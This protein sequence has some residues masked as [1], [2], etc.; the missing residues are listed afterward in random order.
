MMFD[1]NKLLLTLVDAGGGMRVRYAVLKGN[2]VRDEGE[3]AMGELPDGGS[4]RAS[5]LARGSYFDRADTEVRSAKMLPFQ[6]R[7][8]VDGA[9]AFNEPFRVRCIARDLGSGRKRL[10]LLA[11]AEAEYAAANDG[12]GARAAACERLAPVEAA[13]AALVAQETPEPAAVLWQRGVNLLGLLVDNGAVLAKVLDRSN[14]GETADAVEG[15]AGRLERM[16]GSLR[17]AARRIFPDREISLHLVLGDLAG[18][19]EA[20]GEMDNA[21]SSALETR[22][23]R[24][25][26]GGQPNAALQWPEVYGLLTLANEFS[27]LEPERQQRAWA[28]KA[29]LALGAVILTGAAAATATAAFSHAEWQR[30]A[31]EYDSRRGTVEA[32]HAA[33]KPRMPDPAQLAAMAQRVGIEGGAADF[34][35]DSLLAW[36]SEITPRGAII[37]KLEAGAAD[38]GGAPTAATAQPGAAPAAPAVAPNVSVE[39]ELQGDYPEIERL[40]AQLAER[41]GARTKLSG[42]MLTYTPGESGG[43]AARLVTT[44][45]P[46][47]GAFRQ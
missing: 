36:I 21:A 8:L 12:L 34:R 33:L 14:G 22:L 46:L 31:T 30:L 28:E 38:P 13:I 45:A 42:S 32:E 6:A 25:F 16:R 5:F 39:W 9:L 10:D 37:R 3:C 29:A 44:L 7:R 15:Q 19:P 40:A 20:R 18:K 4:L 23:A 17:T 47:P 26:T 43:S 35:I 41:L 24:R 11:V 1:A 27:L 2:A